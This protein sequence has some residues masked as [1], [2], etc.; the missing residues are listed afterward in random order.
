MSEKSVVPGASISANSMSRRAAQRGLGTVELGAGRQVV[1]PALVEEPV[2]DLAG[3]AQALGP[4][5]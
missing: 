2:G 4:S 3:A 1:R 5:D